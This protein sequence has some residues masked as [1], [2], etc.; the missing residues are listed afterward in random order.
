MKYRHCSGCHF[1]VCI[2]T[3]V[4]A[5]LLKVA[6]AAYMQVC[7]TYGQVADH[8]ADVPTCCTPGTSTIS[9]SVGAARAQSSHGTWQTGLYT[10]VIPASH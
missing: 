1:H 3:V 5:S 7:K 2:H 8:A 6:P 9:D 10:A 4:L